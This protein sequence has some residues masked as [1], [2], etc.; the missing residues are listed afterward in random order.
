MIIIRKNKINKNYKSINHSKYLIR[1]HIILTCK[2]RKKLLIKYGTEIKSIFKEIAKGCD[3]YIEEMEVDKDHIHFMINS[4]PKLS[5][6][7]I[8]RH[9]KQCS[10]I[11]IWNAYK[12]ELSKYFWR[13]NTFWT[14]GYFVSSIGEVSSKNLKHYI[15]NQG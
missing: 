1:Y 8:V 13:E 3:F 11:Q 12:E 14:N 4:V 15:E 10:T 6:L 7:Q 9:L 2:Y 5:P